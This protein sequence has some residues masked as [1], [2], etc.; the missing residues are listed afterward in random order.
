MV[1]TD[2]DGRKISFY[3]S[4]IK[5]LLHVS[6]N[7]PVGRLQ[8]PSTWKVHEVRQYED[9]GLWLVTWLE[10]G[11]TERKGAWDITDLTEKGRNVL[12]A[13]NDRQTKKS[14]DQGEQA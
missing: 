6:H 5:K 1:Y 4:G 10:R 7:K 12:R 11:D 14:S 13:W 9:Q 8:A 2:E 3:E